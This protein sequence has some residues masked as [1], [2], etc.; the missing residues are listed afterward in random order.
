[1]LIGTTYENQ[2]AMALE[3]LTCAGETQIIYPSLLGTKYSTL[4]DDIGIGED[5]EDEFDCVVHEYGHHEM[6]ACYG[7]PWPSGDYDRTEWGGHHFEGSYDNEWS[8]FCEGW[9]NFCPVI[10]KGYPKYRIYDVESAQRSAPS[11]KSEGTVCRILWDIADTWSD[12]IVDNELNPVARPLTGGIALDDDPFGFADCSPYNELPGLASLKEIIKNKHPDGITDFR[13]EWRN[14][15]GC[16]SIKYRAL[17]AVYWQNGVKDDIVNHAPQCTLDVAGDFMPGQ[18]TDGEQQPDTYAGD[19]TLT[20]DVY[21]KD[22]LDLQFRHVYFYWTYI[23]AGSGKLS[24]PDMWYLIGVD[25]DGSDGFTCVWPA[26]ASD[27]PSN[28]TNPL[29]VTAVASDF[30]EKS[31]YSL[32]LKHLERSQKGPFIIR[33]SMNTKCME[34]LLNLYADGNRVQL[35]VITPGVIATIQEIIS[36]IRSGWSAV[37]SPNAFNDYQPGE[38]ALDDGTCRYAHTTLAAYESP[39]GEPFGSIGTMRVLFTGVPD[40]GIVRFGLANGDCGIAGATF[41][42]PFEAP[43]QPLYISVGNAI[44]PYGE[45]VHQYFDVDLDDVAVET[46]CEK[47][48]LRLEEISVAPVTSAFDVVVLGNY[49]YV[50]DWEDGLVSI[51]ISD[52]QNPQIISVYDQRTEENSGKWSYAKALSLKDN[53]IYLVTY[54]GELVVIDVSDHYKPKQVG[55]FEGKDSLEGITIASDYAYIAAYRDGLYIFDISDPRNPKKLG[56]ADTPN[57]AFEV[58]VFGSI[59]YIA[60]GGAICSIDISDP[61]NPVLLGSSPIYL[62]KGVAI[63]NDGYVYASNFKGALQVID[64]SNASSP[65][66]IKSIQMIKG[67]FNMVVENGC[68]FTANGSRGMSVY[69]IST[70]D[71]PEVICVF[72]PEKTRGQSR[73]VFVKDDYV[74]LTANRGGLIIFKIIYEQ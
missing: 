35:D 42:G 26:T 45:T 40:D 43:T 37:A 10:T 61:K 12:P 64:F 31:S 67:G 5:E 16:L 62:S 52:P 7:G 57:Y 8:A 25:V 11:T 30:F 72:N 2:P 51:D 32:D 20:A 21:D 14:K 46:S 3:S 44:C 36:P 68:L 65:Q 27:R 1:M 15:H 54:S 70:P 56:V 19:L 34:G 24:D 41:M 23:S 73:N 69:D 22:L 33:P 18:V 28:T 59:A 29:C 55:Y 17:E 66:I 48:K 50:A 9:A 49:A 58:E 47:K 53:Y 71:S 6:A 4:E 60:G 74:Y 38:G 13:T 39:S 63:G